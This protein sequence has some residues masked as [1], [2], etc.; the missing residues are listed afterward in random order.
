MLQAFEKGQVTNQ[1][2][3]KHGGR[4]PKNACTPSSMSLLH[5]VC[6]RFSCNSSKTSGVNDGAGLMQSNCLFSKCTTKGAL[7]AMMLA[8]SCVLLGVDHQGRLTS[9]HWADMSFSWGSHSLGFWSLEVCLDGNT[10]LFCLQLHLT[11]TTL[12]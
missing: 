1:F 6:F 5:Q 3:R 7:D 12:Q 8:I 4:L 2:P 9:C 10:H 11:P